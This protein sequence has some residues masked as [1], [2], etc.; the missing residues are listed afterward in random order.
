MK[1]FPKA[2]NAENDPHFMHMMRIYDILTSLLT[3]P[4]IDM[5][6]RLCVLFRQKIR[7][8]TSSCVRTKPL[9]L[10]TVLRPTP[11]LLSHNSAAHVSN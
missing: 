3:N 4:V 11:F 5:W 2:T 10:I 6:L 7:R 8:G 1:N 9:T